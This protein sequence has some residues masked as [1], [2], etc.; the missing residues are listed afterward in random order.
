MD[1]SEQRKHLAEC[2]VEIKGTY[3]SRLDLTQGKSV[4]GIASQTSLVLGNREMGRFLGHVFRSDNR[5]SCL[6]ETI[7]SISNQPA[8]DQGNI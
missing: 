3:S 1:D 2:C 4:A 6:D 7:E 5:S 8:E